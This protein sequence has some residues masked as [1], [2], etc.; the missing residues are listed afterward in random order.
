MIKGFGPA[1]GGFDEN[2]QVLLGLRLPDVL[3]KS[4]G[5]QADLDAGFLAGLGRR[6]KTL[7]HG[8]FLS[9]GVGA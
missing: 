9:R 1:A 8:V 4:A 7:F 3:V 5:A 2:A 6:D